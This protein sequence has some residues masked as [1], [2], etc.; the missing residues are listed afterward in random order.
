MYVAVKG[1]ERAIDNAHAWLAEERRG[2]LGVAEMS[3]EQIREQLSLAV[4]RV[5]AEGSLYDADL[6]ALAA[7]S[8]DNPYVYG[9]T[10][11]GLD[12]LVDIITEDDGL[13]ERIS[14]SEIRG[15]AE[16]AQGMNEII[17]EKI[18]ETGVANDGGISAYD[19]YLINEAIQN[20][21]DAHERFTELHGNDEDGVETGFHL[22]QGDGSRTE[23]FDRSAVNTVADGIYHMGFDI[24][25]GY[26]VNEDGNKNAHVSYVSDWLNKLL[27]DDFATGT[28]VN[29]DLLPENIDL[30]ALK[31][32]EILSLEDP[33]DVTKSG[34]N[35]GFDSQD[36]FNLAEGTVII[37]FTADNPDGWDRDTL[38]SRDACG[39]GEGGHLTIYVQNNDVVARFQNDQTSVYLKAKDVV[40]AGQQYDVAFSFNG[41]T[42]SLYLD[43]QL[44]DAKDFNATWENAS[45]DMEIGGSLMYRHP[46]NDDVRDRFEGEIDSFQLFDEELNFAEIQAARLEEYDLV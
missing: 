33:I 20:D 45:E 13:I 1:G 32:K 44:Q 5:M 41:E 26:F 46:S 16:A 21:P 19:M 34:G 8:S 10:G 37:G 14:T 40:D 2:D 18:I 24:Q 28:L 42:A 23:L 6:A 7:Q 38:F 11:T 15:G 39:Y 29:E 35:V 25:N 17:I 27:A 36:A 4:N 9:T 22:V 3:L 30:A 12:Q 31:A 43:G